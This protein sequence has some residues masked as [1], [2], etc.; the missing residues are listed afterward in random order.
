MRHY[1]NQDL[2][3]LVSVEEAVNA[4][5]PAF[6]ALA[7]GTAQVQ[8]RMA[9]VSGSLRLNTMAAIAPESGYCAA[10]VYT[11]MGTQYSF[12]ILLFSAKDGRLLATF[13]AGELTKL[14]TAAVTCLA[15]KFMAKPSSSVLTVFGTGTQAAGHAEALVQVLPIDRI[16]IV[17]RGDAS[18]FVGR[19]AATTGVAVKQATAEEGAR[20]ADVI[21]TATRAT[22]P[23]FRGQ[24]VRDGCFIAA[25]G[26]ALPTNAEIDAETILRCG[27]IVVEAMDHAQH[28]AGDLIHAHKAGA[29]DWEKAT[30]LGEI[31]L[32]KA[33]GR[34]SDSEITLFK[35]VG[36]A[37]E[38]VVIAAL[39]YEKLQP[40]PRD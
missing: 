4:L 13:D 3:G 10:K 25:V 11:A 17:S 14:R 5:A 12:V 22:K 15:A 38:D 28:E 34:G 31:L 39:A 37:L 27:H 24:W 6:R 18:A 7:V 8:L 20:T 33:T 29:F 23:L 30:T 32:G 26:S 2:A 1:S 19:T 35:S 40:P 36:C 16:Q 21:V 9:T